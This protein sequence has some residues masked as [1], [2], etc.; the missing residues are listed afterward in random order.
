M[1]PNDIRDSDSGPNNLQ[2]FPD[3]TSVVIN[4]S[5]DLMIEYLVDSDASNSAYPLTV[6]FFISDKA[7]EG[8]MLLGDDT[9]TTA[10]FINEGKSLNL[11]LAATL[12]YT[13]GDGIVATATDADG[14]TSEF[15]EE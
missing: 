5:G 6:Q 15:S 10:D 13:V 14:N 12:G 11:G 3:I 7:G 8:K 9:F 2:N 4:G 1:T